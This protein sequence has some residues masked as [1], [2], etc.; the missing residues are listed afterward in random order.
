MFSVILIGSSFTSYIH[1]N[2][3]S[4]TELKFKGKHLPYLSN[5]ILHVW[6]TPLLCMFFIFKMLHKNKSLLF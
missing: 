6:S 5:G 1:T 2:S 4:K 3:K